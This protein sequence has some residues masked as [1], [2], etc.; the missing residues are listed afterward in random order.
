MLMTSLARS[1][2]SGANSNSMLYVYLTECMLSQATAAGGSGRTFAN[3]QQKMT[4]KTN[5]WIVTILSLVMLNDH[6]M[7]RW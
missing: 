4:M 7:K 6:N 2:F 5:G 3:D 1:D